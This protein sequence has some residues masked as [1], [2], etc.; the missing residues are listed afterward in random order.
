MINTVLNKKN[1]SILFFIFLFISLGFLYFPARYGLIIDDGIT[2]LW[3]IKKYG[4]EGFKKSYGTKNLYYG[5]YALLYFFYSIFGLKSAF[6]FFLFLLFHCLNSVLIFVFVKKLL[7]IFYINKNQVTGIAFWS[8]LMFAFSC[9]QSENI[10]WGATFHYCF[11]LFIL[12]FN[13]IFLIQFFQNNF[14]NYQLGLFYFLQFYAL[15]TLE[16]SLIFPILYGLLFL[17]F[18]FSNENRISIKVFSIKIIMPISLFIVFYLY[19]NG[20]Y[21]ENFLPNFRAQSD[22]NSSFSFMITTINQYLIKTIAFIQELDYSNRIKFYS[23]PIH[24]K[25]T[26]LINCIF[27]FGIGYSFFRQGK[28]QFYLFLFLFIGLLVLFFHFSRL[29]VMY[30]NTLENDRFSYFLLVFLMPLIV[31]F[32]FQFQKYLAHFFLSIFLIINIYFLIPKVNAREIGIQFHNE[33]L[34][35]LPKDLNINSKLYLLNIPRYC[36]D[37]YIFRDVQ[38]VSISYET[39]YNKDYFK[40]I[41]EVASIFNVSKNDSFDVK[42]LSDSSIQVQSKTNGCWW[43]YQSLGATNYETEDYKVKFNDWGGYEIIFKRQFLKNEYLLYYSN[44]KMNRIE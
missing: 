35:Q 40:N 38:R 8:S 20:L 13:L 28:K 41:I 12:F 39:L 1:E 27:I 36:N 6:W 34:A 29:S 5:Y 22:L 44:G 23:M 16:L 25:K 42:R 18:Y 17:L 32:C 24:W 4:I 10:I 14:R 3:E 2:G 26:L 15:F 31:L 33:Y 37:A 11:T 9:Y 19:V 30:V 21:S 43:M 7:P